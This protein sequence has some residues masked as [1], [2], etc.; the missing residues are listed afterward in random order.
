[1]GETMRASGAMGPP[2]DTADGTDTAPG[3]VRA[4]EVIGAS[5]QTVTRDCRC[6]GAIRGAGRTRRG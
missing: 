4:L 6:I 1:M 2:S 3:V 5:V